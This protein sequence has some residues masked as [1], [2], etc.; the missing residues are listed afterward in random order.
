MAISIARERPASSDVIVGN[1]MRNRMRNSIIISKN[2]L[3]TSVLNL[4]IACPAC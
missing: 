4:N 1:R 3:Y 2:L